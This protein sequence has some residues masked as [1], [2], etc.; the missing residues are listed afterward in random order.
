MMVYDAAAANQSEAVRGDVFSNREI[1]GR[2]DG[3]V[4]GCM[5]AWTDA[6][7]S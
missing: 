5:H 6:R 4:H 2:I 7:R 1:K 3:F